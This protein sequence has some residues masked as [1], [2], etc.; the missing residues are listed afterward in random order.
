VVGLPSRR[1]AAEH[2]EARFGV[3]ERRACK[4]LRLHRSSKR[5]RSTAARDAELRS[6]I[7]RL[8]ARYPRA[9][10]RQIHWL[11]QREGYRVGRE[12]VRRLRRQEG[13]SLERR[14]RRAR[15]HQ[16]T[17]PAQQAR[18]PHHVWSVDFVADQT[19][20]GRRL[21]CLTVLDE[22]TRVGL[23]IHVA[24][25][26][27]AAEVKRE[28]AQLF[29]Y[30]GPPAYLKSDNGPE[31]IAESLREWLPTKGVQTHTIAPGSPWQNGHSESFN[32]IFRDGCLNRWWFSSISEAREVIQAWLEEYNQERP[33]GALEG[34][35]PGEYLA[36]HEGDQ[37]PAKAA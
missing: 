5:R 16:P 30:Y 31:F 27:T 2:L 26:I 36:R 15:R 11:L 13:L 35:T 7:H 8:S 24:R 19:A 22:Y 18:Y 29:A 32:G 9:G 21:R 17:A 37:T 20:D 34:L 23:K 3:S 10:Y 6:A 12:R 4:V 14:K 33:H 1:R 28:L 25:S